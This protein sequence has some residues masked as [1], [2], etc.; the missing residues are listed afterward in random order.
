[1]EPR[2]EGDPCVATCQIMALMFVAAFK[3]LC[4]STLS[5]LVEPCWEAVLAELGRGSK[6]ADIVEL[7]TVMLR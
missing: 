5:V 4:G 1:A 6:S 7:A 3:E 2:E